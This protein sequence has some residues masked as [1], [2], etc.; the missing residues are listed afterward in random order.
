MR[1]GQKDQQNPNNAGHDS[2]FTE[3]SNYGHQ[4]A[5]KHQDQPDAKMNTYIVRSTDGVCTS[6]NVA[7]KHSGN[8]PSQ[9]AQ[10]NNDKS[11]PGQ[12]DQNMGQ[13]LQDIF[14]VS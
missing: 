3:E 8:D 12:R 9:E 1:T 11:Y 10:V 13:S 5:N 2:N 14:K 7:S 4:Q 6:P